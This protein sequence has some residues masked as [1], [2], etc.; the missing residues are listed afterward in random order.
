MRDNINL[1][2]IMDDVRRWNGL[3]EGMEDNINLTLIMDDV[4]DEW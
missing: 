4:S 3:S 1:T 2:L